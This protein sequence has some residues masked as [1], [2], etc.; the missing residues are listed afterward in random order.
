MK[1]LPEEVS[2][3]QKN[4]AQ[5]GSRLTDL[6]S[7]LTKSETDLRSDLGEMKQDLANDKVTKLNVY[8]ISIILIKMI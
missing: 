4:V 3:V 5:F 7:H 2:D 6:E 1:T 8:I